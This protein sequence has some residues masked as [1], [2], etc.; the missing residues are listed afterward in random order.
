[1]TDVTAKL[2]V[3]SGNPLE[4]GKNSEVVAIGDK[5]SSCKIPYTNTFDFFDGFG[6]LVENEIVICPGWN[7][8]TTYQTCWVL[9]KE[10][11]RM[12][13]LL[14][15][16]INAAAIHVV[17]KGVSNFIS[18]IGNSRIEPITNLFYILGL[19]DWWRPQQ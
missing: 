5:H 2:L 13:R 17:N 12:I 8:V 6:L 7:G 14:D 1:M 19:G 11:S 9:S 18:R 15:R 16:R 3:V 4:N 10:N